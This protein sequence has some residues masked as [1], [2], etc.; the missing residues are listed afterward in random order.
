MVYQLIP[1]VGTGT[2][3][4]GANLIMRFVQ[5]GCIDRPTYL[6]VIQ[7]ASVSMFTIPD[8]KLIIISICRNYLKDM[9]RLWNRLVHMIQ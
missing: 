4:R 5:R 2:Y 7:E 6:L 3:K 9:N 1:G 8:H